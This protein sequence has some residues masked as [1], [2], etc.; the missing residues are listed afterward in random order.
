MPPL[1]AALAAG[2]EGFW[3]LSSPRCGVI[4]IHNHGGCTLSGG[5]ASAV[6]GVGSGFVVVE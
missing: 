1:L 6:V 5:Q 2:G 4:D 3:F